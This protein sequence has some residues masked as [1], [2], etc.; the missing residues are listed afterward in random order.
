MWKSAFTTG[1]VDYT[2]S[3][4]SITTH[5]SGRSETMH[6]QV[7]VL[8]RCCSCTSKP[9]FI[10]FLNHDSVPWI[11]FNYLKTNCWVW[12]H[13]PVNTAIGGGG[14]H[15]YKVQFR[16]G[17][18]GDVFSGHW[19]LKL[20]TRVWPLDPT[21]EGSNQHV[22]HHTHINTVMNKNEKR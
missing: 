11:S 19:P 12:R 2:V 22:H 13:T 18:T 8:H 1:F 17:K 7:A 20:R 9:N 21:V 6:K 10:S 16:A 3:G 5:R 4:N 14:W 15:F